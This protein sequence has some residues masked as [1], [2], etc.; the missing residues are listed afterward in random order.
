MLEELNAIEA[1]VA[2]LRRQGVS[3]GR[4][5][6][7][8]LIQRWLEANAAWLAE[9]LALAW[10]LSIEDAANVEPGEIVVEIPANASAEERRFLH[11]QA[12]LL[13]EMA[14]LQALYKDAAD[15]P[16]QRAIGQWQEE[17][18]ARLAAH[19]AEAKRLSTQ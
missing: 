15:E 7:Q 1:A 3:A 12:A 8:Q 18:R 14:E 11:E 10:E 13:G 2:D 9:H 6:V 16:R 5:N 19:F 4:E 17:N